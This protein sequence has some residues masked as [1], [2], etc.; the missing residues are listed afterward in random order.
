MSNE[1]K[2]VFSNIMVALIEQKC[3]DTRNVINTIDDVYN[4]LTEIESR[5]SYCS[6]RK[7]NPVDTQ[8]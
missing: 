7:I 5:S 3:V 2:N 1:M 4:K 6:Y 8:L